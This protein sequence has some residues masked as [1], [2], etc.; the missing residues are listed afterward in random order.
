[1]QGEGAEGT[2]AEVCRQCVGPDV[3]PGEPAGQG[4]ARHGGRSEERG[5][6]SLTR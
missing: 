3:R 6:P 2:T 1:M 4:V 5:V